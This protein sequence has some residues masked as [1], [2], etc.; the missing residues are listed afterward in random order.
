MRTIPTIYELKITLQDTRPPVWRRFSAPGDVSLIRL[1]GHLQRIMGWTNA[2][3][4]QF[5][6]EG[7]HFGTP[8]PDFPR[9]TQTGKNVPLNQVLRKPNDRFVY[10]YDFGDGWQHEIVLER[11]V[12]A[13]P[14]RLYP[15]VMDGARACPPEDCGGIAGYQR[16]LE[17]LAS[18]KHPDH[19]AVLAWVGGSYDPTA[20][21]PDAMN[22]LL[23]PGWRQGGA[24]R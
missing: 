22:G 15:Y 4:H 17:A 20:F 11:V 7:W 3:M 21:D 5:I 8:D 12:A 24:L 13:E 2:H 9:P 19:G 1:H 6:A 23:H 10:E 16:L 18:S 14:D